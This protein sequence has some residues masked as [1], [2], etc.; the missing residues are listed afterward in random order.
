MKETSQS[1]S[2]PARSYV[3]PQYASLVMKLR[4][5]LVFL[6]VSVQKASDTHKKIL[7]KLEI[8]IDDNKTT[9]TSKNNSDY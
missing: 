5:L 6:R 9:V 3:N 8:I 1:N 4:K 2:M 7:Q